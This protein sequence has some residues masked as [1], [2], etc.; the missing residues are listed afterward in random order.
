MFCCSLKAITSGF[1]TADDITGKGDDDNADDSAD[2]DQGTPRGP[3][4]SKVSKNGDS[5]V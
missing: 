4:Y 2:D 3:K 5:S 1:A